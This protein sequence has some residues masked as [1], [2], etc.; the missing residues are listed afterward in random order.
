MFHLQQDFFGLQV[1]LQSW[2]LVGE[3]TSNDAP[4]LGIS[5]Q[6]EKAGED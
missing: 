6:D 3:D 2:S 1:H 5:H 4:G